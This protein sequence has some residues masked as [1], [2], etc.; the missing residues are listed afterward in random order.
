MQCKYKTICCRGIKKTQQSVVIFPINGETDIRDAIND[1]QLKINRKRKNVEK[2]V[3]E[4]GD[5]KCLSWG[6]M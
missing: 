1:I 6:K 3:L 2:I 5:L 4:K